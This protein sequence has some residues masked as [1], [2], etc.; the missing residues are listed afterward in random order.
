MDV[1]HPSLFC[2][3]VQY[4]FVFEPRE[5]SSSRIRE[6]RSLGEARRGGDAD[7]DAGARRLIGSGRES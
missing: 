7:A 2:R 5:S 4:K 6:P 1:S 3:V